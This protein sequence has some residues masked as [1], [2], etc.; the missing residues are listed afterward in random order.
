MFDKIS[1][2]KNEFKNAYTELGVKTLIKIH[3][4]D[5]T[6]QT[7]ISVASVIGMA[8]GLIVIAAI[9]PSAIETFYATDTSTWLLEAG[10]ETGY[11][12]VEDS[13]AVTLWWLLPFIAVA[14]VLYMLYKR[15][16]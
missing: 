7:E 5:N 16:E 14:T 3:R 2:L 1:A 4:L 15:M 8:I 12:S 11:G 13:K 6:A 9:I 10:N